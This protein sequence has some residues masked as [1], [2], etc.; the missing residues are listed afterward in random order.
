ML[1]LHGLGAAILDLLILLV[2]KRFDGL[3]DTF[4]V[5]ASLVLDRGDLNSALLSGGSEA[6]SQLFLLSTLLGL[7]ALLDEL[8][9]ALIL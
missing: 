2:L 4:V 6:L 5:S 1:A 7:D 9:L 8:R 3:D